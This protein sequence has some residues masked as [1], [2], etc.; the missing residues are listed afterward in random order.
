M[1]KKEHVKISMIITA[2]FQYKTK[3]LVSSK[4]KQ[5]YLISL[6][7]FDSAHLLYSDMI[8]DTVTVLSMNILCAGD[9]SPV[10]RG[11]FTNSGAIYCPL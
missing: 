3:L 9:K 10:Q 2:C 1:N 5:L 6:E 8:F 7:L 11:F 4:Y